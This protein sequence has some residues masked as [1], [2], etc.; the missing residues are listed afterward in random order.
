MLHDILHEKYKRA[1]CL[2]HLCF[3]PHIYTNNLIY[4]LY[5]QGIYHLSIQ[6]L[7]LNYLSHKASVE[8]NGVPDP[9][10]MVYGVH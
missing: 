4:L 9:Q 7:P 3:F 5:L 2:P 8:T 10:Q 6:V 1:Q